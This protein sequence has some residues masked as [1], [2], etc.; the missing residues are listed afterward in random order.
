MATKTFNESES[1][2]TGI[3]FIQFEELERKRARS[4]YEKMLLRQ[5]LES[6]ELRTSSNSALQ[7]L[8]QLQ[9]CM[10]FQ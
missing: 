7:E 10:L 6:E 1:G 4:E 2:V 3:F 8:Q 9:V 5:D